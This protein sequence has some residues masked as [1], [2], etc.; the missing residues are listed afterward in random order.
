[1]PRPCIPFASNGIPRLASHHH[2]ISTST[3]ARG[4]G[5]P[6]QMQLRPVRPDEYARLGALTLDAY[7]SL[8]G[9]VHEPEYEEELVDVRSRAEAPA[10]KVFVAFD[11]CDVDED[12]HL[13]GGVT[14]IVDHTSP[15]AEVMPEDAAAIRMLAVDRSAQRGGIGRFLVGHCITLAVLDHKRWLVLHSTPW[16]TGAH[17]L[18]ERLGFVRDPDRDWQVT[19][20]VLLLGFRLDL[21]QFTVTG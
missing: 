7:T 15:F 1:M 12:D 13:L 6:D 21:S 20:E 8:P 2:P 3:A 10:T 9:H 11:Y 5:R 4:S 19:P 17:R 18:Y 16:M 14:F